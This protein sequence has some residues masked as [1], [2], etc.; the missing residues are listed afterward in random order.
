MDKTKPAHGVEAT[1]DKK[2][3]LL[4]KQWKYALYYVKSSNS[5]SSSSY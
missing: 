1:A 2:L 5:L 3:A 4:H